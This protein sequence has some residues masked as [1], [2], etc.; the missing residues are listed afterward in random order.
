[1]LRRIVNA[2][3][4]PSSILLL[5]LTVFAF[6]CWGQ[7]EEQAL[8]SLRNF[9]GG[10]KN[11]PQDVVSQIE[12]RFAGKR[13]GALAKL[14]HAKIKFDEKDFAGAALLLN[15]DE[16]A[17][18]TNIADHALFLRGQS[19]QQSEQY[20]EAM[21][22][23]EKLINEHPQSIRINDAKLFWADSAT[24]G[25]FASRVPDFLDGINSADALLRIAK[26]YE[27]QNKSDDALKFY[28]RTY[29]HGAGT[30]AAKEAEAKLTSL[31]QP[32]TPQ[33]ADEAATR[34]EKLYNSKNWA[35]ADKAY[36][37]LVINYPASL[38][39]PIQ[40]KR[41]TVLANVRKG[42]EAQA[43]FN[44]IPAS[45]KEKEEAYYQ[46]VMAYAKAKMWPDARRMADEMRVKYPAGKFTVKAWV[47]A[48]MAAREAKNKGEEQGFL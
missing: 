22:T 40:L 45:A 21:R 31:A 20:A 17:R 37:D 3:K 33:N 23:F 18:L 8:Q 25:G 4:T 11:P 19:L 12:R 14:V 9:A 16:F 6:G 47:D 36:S 24:A 42:I 26:A 38:T 46:L 41:L 30:D 34:A 7:T 13:T 39:P 27:A 44:S 1:M 10:G 15:T 5:T 29:F 35:T 43:V 28:R 32:L 48:G 2:S